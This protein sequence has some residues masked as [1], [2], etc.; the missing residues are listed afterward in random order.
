[1]PASFDPAAADVRHDLPPFWLPVLAGLP[2]ALGLGLLALPLLGYG[3]ATIAR[4]LYLS[5]FLVWLLPLT[6][7]QRNLWRRGLRPRVLVPALLL[8]T[9]LMALSARVATLAGLALAAG[10]PLSGLET[11]QFWRGLEAPWL[12]L[13]AYAALHAVI[14]YAWALRRARERLQAAQSLAREAGLRALQLQLQPHFLFNTLNAVSGLVA[15]GEAARAQAMLARL[16]DFLRATLA[17][18]DGHEVSLA[19]ELAFTEA[20]LDIEKAR[21]GDRLRVQ[22]HVGP[23]LLDARVPWLVLQPLVENAIRHG[24]AARPGPGRLEIDLRADGGQLQACVRNE[25]PAVAAPAGQGIGLANLAA[26]L[27]QLYPGEQALEAGPD[28]DTHWQAR[29]RWPLRRPAGTAP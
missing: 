20:Y 11:G 15:A 19:D 3:P 28:G 7:L 18:R 4:T 26:R 10:A 13:V 5:T 6:A 14:T 23:G 22:W 24:I 17:P 1:M 16:G 29:L 27:A 8:A 9:L 2:L 12:G 21:L 25:R